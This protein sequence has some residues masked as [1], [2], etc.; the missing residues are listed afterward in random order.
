MLVK[1]TEV[2]KHPLVE[3][4]LHI[5]LRLDVDHDQAFFAF[6]A[7][8]YQNINLVFFADSDVGKDLLLQESYMGK[9]N[10]FICPG[11][12]GLHEFSKKGLD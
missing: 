2:D 4:F 12:K 9:I 5:T 8:L 1:T 11:E 3:F 10:G 6:K 7:G